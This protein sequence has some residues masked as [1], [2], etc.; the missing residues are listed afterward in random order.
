MFITIRYSLFILL[1]LPKLHFTIALFTICILSEL[2]NYYKLI[3][4]EINSM[5][6]FYNFEIKVYITSNNIFFH[7]YASLIKI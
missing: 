4:M 5:Y 3:V 6:V 7:V 2:E 1:S